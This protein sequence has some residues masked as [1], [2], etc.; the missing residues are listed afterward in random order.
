MLTAPAS[1][2]LPKP[3]VFLAR[4][5][6][7]LLHPIFLPVLLCVALYVLTPAAFKAFPPYLL[8]RS[9]VSIAI[10]TIF[11]PLFS[12][13]LMKA[14]GFIKSVYM[15]DSK[16]R[17]IPLIATMTF[18]FWA[19]LV[20]S[21]PLKFAEKTIDVPL[22]IRV[23]LL[24]AFYIIVV[25][26]MVN[27]FFKVSMHSTAAGGAIGFGL[28]LLLTSPTN[29]LLPFFAFVIVA[30]IIGSARLILREHKPSEVWTGYAL[31]F[32]VQ[33]AAWLYLK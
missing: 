7:I 30:G 1:A 28:V 3:V 15:R 14:L 9:L 33:M 11:F 4:F 12:I 26:F 2:P 29:M 16:D 8:V 5:V 10:I 27:I 13:I 6:S 32:I 17:I 22:L 25:L 21:H 19:Y 23:I 18:F 20:Y 24:G 31:G